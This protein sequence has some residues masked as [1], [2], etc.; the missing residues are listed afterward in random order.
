[1]LE[2]DPQQITR[3]DQIGRPVSKFVLLAIGLGATLALFS[4]AFLTSF[5]PSIVCFAFA[6]A[7]A[8]RGLMLNYPHPSLG[9]CNTVTLLR[10]ALVAFLVGAIFDPVISVWVTF[11]VAT[12]A[13]A[14]DGADGWLARR[15]GMTSSFGSSFDMET[16]AALGAVLALGLLIQGN[17]GL[18]ILVLGCMRYL[19][20]ASSLFVP[21]L[22]GDLPESYRR[23][24]ICVVQIAALIILLCPLTPVSFLMPI[25]IIAAALLMWSF[26]VDTLWLLRPSV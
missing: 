3:L 12:I 4:N 21:A 20:V 23:K 6:A 17:V 16:D 19:F 18:E 7:L 5:I 10:V 14:L 9:W 24:A 22:R 8:T 15:D 11:V 13:F 2:T 25:S 26:A 1:M